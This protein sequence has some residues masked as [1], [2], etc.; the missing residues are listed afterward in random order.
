[1][2][3]MAGLRRDSSAHDPY[4]RGLDVAVRMCARKARTRAEV[5]ERLEREGLQARDV[6]RV[7]ARLAELGALDDSAL[8]RAEAAALLERRGLGPLLAVARLVARGV[9]ER[10]ARAAVAERMAQGELSL[11]RAALARRYGGVPRDPRGRAR[12]VRWLSARG[13]SP[14]TAAEAVGLELELV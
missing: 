14:E 13:F 7:M 4:T 10:E 6:A 2:A 5:R 3:G 1:M 9:A 12:A 11:A 8:A